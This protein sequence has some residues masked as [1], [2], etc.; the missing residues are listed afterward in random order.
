MKPM[1]TT[2]SIALDTNVLIYL[3]DKEDSHK[4]EIANHPITLHPAISTQVVSEFLNVAR[5]LLPIPKQQI[6]SK[7][8]ELFRLCTIVPVNHN[9]LEKAESLILHYD[10]QIFDAIIVAT[11]LENNYD[12][13]YSEDMQHGLKV[14]R[15][16]KIINPFL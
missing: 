7:C 12:T 4:K 13:L 15:K 6:I 10:F 14:E 3:F 5:R 11:A 16:L 1:S 2:E 8:N 9:C